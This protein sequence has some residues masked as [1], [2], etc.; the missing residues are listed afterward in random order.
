[1]IK[2]HGDWNIQKW[3]EWLESQGL[4]IGRDFR[5]AWKDNAWAVEFTNTQKETWVRLRLRES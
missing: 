1:V 5:W 2:L 3:Y 4:E